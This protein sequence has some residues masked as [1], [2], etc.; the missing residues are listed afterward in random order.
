MKEKLDFVA[1]FSRN[2]LYDSLA[3]LCSWAAVS[4]PTSPHSSSAGGSGLSGAQQERQQ[5]MEAFFQSQALEILLSTLFSDELQQLSSRPDVNSAFQA[6]LQH[7]LLLNGSDAQGSATVQHVTEALGTLIAQ[8]SALRSAQ[9]LPAFAAPVSH[10]HSLLASQ[11]A[12]CIKR[13]YFQLNFASASANTAHSGTEDASASQEHSNEDLFA[14][15]AEIDAQLNKLDKSAAGKKVAAPAEIALEKAQ[16]L[17]LGREMH[18]DKM[19]TCLEVSAIGCSL[20]S[21][22]ES[23]MLHL[24][25]SAATMS[26]NAHLLFSFIYSPFDS[27]AAILFCPHRA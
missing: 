25:W 17:F 12:A 8:I 9:V 3:A 2:S 1:G 19:S 7:I 5:K 20:F 16:N 21:I 13:L 4:L 18:A 23:P 6:L 22:V 11:V 14:K 24:G 27:L 10:G 15:L 26:R